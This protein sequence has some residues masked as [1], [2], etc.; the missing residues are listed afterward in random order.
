MKPNFFLIFII[1]I[2]EGNSKPELQSFQVRADFSNLNTED[3]Y[4]KKTMRIEFDKITQFF[5]QL[6]Q[7]PNYSY[8]SK[9][10]DKN[11]EKILKCNVTDIQLK[12]EKESIDKNIFLLI[13]PR[14]IIDSTTKIKNNPILIDCQKKGTSSLVIIL[15]FYFNSERH[16]KRVIPLNFKNNKYQWTIIRHIL[17]SLGFNKES[18]STLKLSNNILLNDITSLKKQSYYKSFKKF[19]FLTNLKLKKSQSKEKFLDYWPSITKLNDIMKDGINLRIN[20][21]TISEMTLGALEKLGYWVNP[22]ELIMYKNKCYRVNQKCFNNFTYDDYFLEYIPDFK[23]KRWICYYK[24][25]EHFKNNQCSSDYGVLLS[26]EEI[27]KPLLIDFIRQTQDFQNLVLLKPAPSCPKPH[28]RTIFFQTVKQGE[29]PYQYK[30]LERAEEVTIKDPNY[31]V[32]TNTFSN[33][34]SV[35]SRAAGY[36]NVLRNNTKGWNYNYLWKVTDNNHKDI[37]VNENKNKYQFIGNFPLDDTYKDGLNRFYNKFKDKFPKDYNYI[38]ETYLFP[39]QKNEILQKFKHYHYDPKNVWLFKPARDSFGHGIKIL[40]NYDDIKNAKQKR[41]LISRYIMNPLLINN[42]KFDM[43]AYVL[44]TGMNPLKIYFYRDGYLKLTVKNFTLS[45]EYIDDGCVHITTSDTNL[46]CFDGKEYKYD[47]DIYDEKSHFYSYVYF[48]RYCAKNG[49]N[50]TDIMN[51]MKDI[52]VKTFISLNSDFLELM[53]KRANK[54]RNSYQLYG[55]DLIIDQNHRVHLLELNRNPTMRNGHAVCDYMY[56]SLITDILNIIGIVPFNHNETQQPL[57][58]DV[59]IYDN[60][61]E[62]I[63]DDSLCEFGRPR[64]MFDLVYPLKNNVNKYK[65]F[66]DKILPE[67]QLL[68]D[69]LLKSNG[70]YD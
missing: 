69:K 17:R 16:M 59:Y 50:Y 35:K 9:E 53:E 13:F 6:L 64:G 37:G 7:Y 12:Y 68:W 20:Y 19:S 58:K 3:L 2:I 26:Y 52:F 60:K 70:E 44:V 49:I 28:P 32:V 1:L 40:D 24:T 25:K 65:K 61:V 62:E 47:I 27:N 31:Y 11:A 41:F 4:I 42:K 39:E 5:K 30:I 10:N 15:D 18:F 36:N 46:E 56:D 34:Y 48:E 8:L 23:K 14:I 45:H 29:D 38:P 43:R 54:D 63:V 22:C 51:Q 33:Y 67:S 57:D 66:Y 21:P 55:L